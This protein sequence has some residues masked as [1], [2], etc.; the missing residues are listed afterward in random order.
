MPTLH[1]IDL[2][3]WNTVESWKAVRDA[4]LRMLQQTTVAEL[5]AKG[6]PSPVAL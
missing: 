1:A 2:S 4:Y 5:V 6:E 3:H